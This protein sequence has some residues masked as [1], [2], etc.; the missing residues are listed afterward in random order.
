MKKTY[1]WIYENLTKK[2]PATEKFIKA[3]IKK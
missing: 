2:D 3:D 1:E